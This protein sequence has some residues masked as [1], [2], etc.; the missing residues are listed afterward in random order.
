MGDGLVALGKVKEAVP[1]F[2]KAVEIGEVSKH[3][4]LELFKKN[5][6]SAEVEK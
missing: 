4:D 6:A 3:S 5:L 2:Q 1:Y